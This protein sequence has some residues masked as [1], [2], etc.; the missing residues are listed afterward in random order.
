V[1]PE[2]WHSQLLN[3]LDLLQHGVGARPERIVLAKPCYNYGDE[4]CV[5]PLLTVY[6]R[7]VDA[8]I[9]SRGLRRGPDFFSAF[10]GA[11]RCWYG[12]DI[13][14]P[15]A[16]GMEHMAGLWADAFPD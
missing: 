8:V 15:D 14:H 4:A 2:L 3:L 9:A 7:I 6:A 16:A 10:Q 12:D 5:A 13:V 11:G 1:A